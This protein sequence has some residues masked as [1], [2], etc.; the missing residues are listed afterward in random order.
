MP[1]LGKGALGVSWPPFHILHLLS[2]VVDITYMVKWK[3]CLDRTTTCT[4]VPFLQ[5]QD[6]RQ[7]MILQAFS[8]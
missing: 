2:D 4:S 1:Q 7:A 3:L 6:Q 5:H 8:S